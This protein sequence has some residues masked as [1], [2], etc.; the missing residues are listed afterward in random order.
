MP[1]TQYM[2]GVENFLKINYNKNIKS[3]RW[4][5][6]YNRTKNNET[7]TN[8]QQTKQYTSPITSQYNSNSNK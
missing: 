5:Y 6:D 7:F 4:I 2:H 8:F 3:E 1:E